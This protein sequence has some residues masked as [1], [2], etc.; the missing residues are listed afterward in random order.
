ML[1]VASIIISNRY[2]A[3]RRD[4]M[5]VYVK[6]YRDQQIISSHTATDDNSSPPEALLG[7]L[8]QIFYALDL[9]EPVFLSKHTRDFSRFQRTKLF[10]SDFVEP[11]NFDFLEIEILPD[12]S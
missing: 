11:V 12:H 5:R 1:Y 8:E 9:A 7:C 2:C 6:I 4:V 10:P 3:L